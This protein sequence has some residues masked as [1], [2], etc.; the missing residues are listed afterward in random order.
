SLSL[1]LRP[2]AAW[3]STAPDESGRPYAAWTAEVKPSIG[4]A[5]GLALLLLALLLL[6]ALRRALVLLLLALLLVWGWSRHRRGRGR[7]RL[8]ALGERQLD[9]TH[10]GGVRARRGR[11]GHV[12]VVDRAGALAL[13]VAEPGRALVHYR[14]G[15]GRF[16][17][18]R[19]T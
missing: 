10:I 18:P 11:V 1:L 13:I 12:R 7:G 19:R 14:A 16:H 17:R 2:H 5:R 9:R 4:R 6:G 3:T 8:W 15:R